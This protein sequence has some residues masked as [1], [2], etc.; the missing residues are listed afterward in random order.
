LN[1]ARL[2]RADVVAAVAAL[3]LLFV[4]ASDWYSTVHGEEARR[5]E[6]LS[7]PQGAA[8]GEI[9]R[10]TREAGRLAGEN[11]ERNAWQADGG[12]D[13]L[14]L[15]LLLGAVVMA[16]LA[17][18]LRTAGRRPNPPLTPSALGAVLAAAGGLLVAYRIWQE[19]GLDSFNTVKAGAPL[20]VVVLGVPALALVSALRGED[21]GAAWK[22]I[23]EVDARDAAPPPAAPPPTAASTRS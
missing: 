17:A 23:Q 22:R 9:E 5:V 6:E 3:V 13:R 19:P 20:A 4:M 12:V 14:I 18:V 8:A 7:D 11:A 2:Q 21:S 15:L 10:D 1:L 16:L